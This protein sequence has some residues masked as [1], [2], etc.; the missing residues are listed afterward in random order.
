M[1]KYRESTKIEHTIVRVLILRP[2]NVD[3][4]VILHVYQINVQCG[5][6]FAQL[7]C[8]EEIHF[9]YLICNVLKGSIFWLSH[10]AKITRKNTTFILFFSRSL[11]KL[12][13]G[14]TFSSFTKNSQWSLRSLRHASQRQGDYSSCGV[15]CALFGEFFFG[16]RQSL[17]FDT[18]PSTIKFQRLAIWRTMVEHAVATGSLCR[19]CGETECPKNPGGK[20]DKWVSD[21]T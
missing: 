10:R 8:T 12:I 2:I 15:I 9:S 11:L 1:F 17:M 13:I 20:V 4:S 6:T 5:S 7:I 3:S 18:S 19:A 14:C 21:D 16:Q